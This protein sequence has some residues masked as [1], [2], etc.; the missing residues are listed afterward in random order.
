MAIEDA[1]ILA[2]LLMTEPDSISAFKRFEAMRRPRV[3]RVRKT[4]DFN[5]FAYHLE[6]PFT[7]ARNLVLRA[8]GSRAHLR[9]LDW[10][11]GFDAAP[12]PP[13]P[14]PPDRAQREPGTSRP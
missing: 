14:P 1:A 7:H 5:G 3:E 4:S 8:Q 11:Y 9:R 13:M 10:L 2:P 6:W 12:E